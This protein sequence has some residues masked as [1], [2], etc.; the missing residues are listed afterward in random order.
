MHGRPRVLSLRMDQSARDQSSIGKAKAVNGSQAA[1]REAGPTDS[2]AAAGS[3]LKPV[4]LVSRGSGKRDQGL[5]AQPLVSMTY[6][7][8][9]QGL[10]SWPSCPAA[11]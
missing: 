8:V 10:G 7:I 6:G 11:G 3:V 9:V 4:F 2:R 1:A 5:P